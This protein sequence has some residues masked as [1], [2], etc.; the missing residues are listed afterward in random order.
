MKKIFRF[1]RNVQ[2]WFLL[3]FCDT[4]IK[5]VQFPAFKVAFR[6]FTTEIKSVSGNFTLKTTGMVYP[7]AFLY[8]ALA[9]GNEGL[10]QWY[11]NRIY[12]LTSLL[13]TDQELANDVQKALTKY[14]KRLQ[15]V[16]ERKAKEV[17]E[18]AEAVAAEQI[19]TNIEYANMTKKQRKQ[20]KK[21]LREELRNMSNEKDEQ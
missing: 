10:V 6:K 19:K 5:S 20:Y 9:Q 12:E 2:R 1:F 3:I 11:C 8:N 17:T 13:L 4:K 7:N 16:A 21:A 15:V 14:D 18:E